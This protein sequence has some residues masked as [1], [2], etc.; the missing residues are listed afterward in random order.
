MWE[1]V[2]LDLGIY[3]P[4]FSAILKFP[5]EVDNKGERYGPT[6]HSL[7]SSILNLIGAEV[8]IK[9]RIATSHCL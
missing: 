2:N 9:I 5:P 1:K 3:Y 8:L 7:I 4:P 6:S